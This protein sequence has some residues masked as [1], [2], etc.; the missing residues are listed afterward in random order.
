MNEESTSTDFSAYVFSNASKKLY[1]DNK[2]EHFKVHLPKPIS[3]NGD[4]EVGVSLVGFE[5]TW[6]NI[7]TQC[8]FKVKFSVVKDNVTVVDSF[9]CKFKPGYYDSAET[10]IQNINWLIRSNLSEYITRQTALVTTRKVEGI[11][12]EGENDE[13]E[14]SR[15][16]FGKLELNK[17]LGRVK[18][19]SKNTQFEIEIVEGREIWAA[20]GVL[21]ETKSLKATTGFQ[22]E[23]AMNLHLPTLF[24][25]SPII[26]YQSVGDTSAPLLALA[27]IQGAFGSYCF[28][29]Y[30][31]PLYCKLAHNY[32]SD[33]EI[34]IL[35]HR[36]IQ[37][38]LGKAV[39]FLLL[40]FRKRS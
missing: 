22:F 23:P 12:A 34:Q 9:E 20:L 16:G 36:G 40:L 24:I 27:P 11:A 18:I 38:P 28:Y 8:V 39:T 5:N 37:V 17:E 35:D 14:V 19:V 21:L 4:W 6:Q 10:I 13:N 7:K 15:L 26:E 31:R 32:I 33:L 3:L 30:D 2:A 29:K 25:Y 1:P